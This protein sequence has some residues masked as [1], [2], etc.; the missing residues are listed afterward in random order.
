LKVEARPGPQI[1]ESPEI[2]ALPAAAVSSEEIEKRL[3]V[4]SGMGEA[5]DWVHS[6]QMA[7]R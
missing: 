2:Q 3:K 5:S 4:R 6:T 7:D 1:I